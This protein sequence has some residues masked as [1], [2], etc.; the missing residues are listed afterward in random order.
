MSSKKIYFLSILGGLA[1]GLIVIMA[2]KYFPTL[3]SKQ[4]ATVSLP[5]W[6]EVTPPT[7]LFTANFP[8]SP[9]RTETELP[10]PGTD[11]SLIQELHVA[12]DAKGNV[13]RVATFVYPKPFEIEQ[14]DKILE[15]SLQGVVEAAPGSTLLEGTTAT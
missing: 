2:V 14:A 9:E 5:G 12:I 13:F 7:R 1:I 4:N 6:V 10:I 8:V 11:Y 15:S 3:G